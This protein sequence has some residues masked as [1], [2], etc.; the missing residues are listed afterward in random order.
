MGSLMLWV[1]SFVSYRGKGKK[2]MEEQSISVNIF[3][4]NINYMNYKLSL[5]KCTT[6]KNIL[7]LYYGEMLILEIL[8][9]FLN[10]NTA[11]S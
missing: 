3:H 8:F 6:K 10:L 5:Y 9:S 2:Q 4:I 11:K 1:K 7:T